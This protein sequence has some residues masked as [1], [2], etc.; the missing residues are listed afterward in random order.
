MSFNHPTTVLVIGGG[1]AGIMAAITAAREG[2][3][4]TILEKNERIG[5]K[6]LATGNGRCNLTNTDLHLKH[7]HGQNPKFAYTALTEFNY[8]NTIDFFA[9]LG[10]MPKTETGGKVFPFSGQASSVLDVLRFEMEQRKIIVICQADINKIKKTDNNFYATCKDGRKF[11][12]NRL[13]LAAGGKAS[14]NLGSNG[15]GFS[16]AQSLGHHIIEP[17]PALV[18]LQLAESFLKQVQGFK[19][20][21]TAEIIV[22][23]KA[24]ARATGEI[25]FTANGISG[26]PILQLSRKA[27]EYL[28]KQ[29]KVWLKLS[30][31]NHLS[32]EQLEQI[33]L[34]RWHNQPSQSLAFSFTGFIHKRIIPAML[35]AAGIEDI[36]KKVS[37]LSS[38]E[39]KQIA[40]ILQD[41]RFQV[42]GTDSWSAA[43]VTAGGVAVNEVN[44]QTLESKKVKGLYLAGEILDID[45]DCGGYNLQWAWSSGYIAGK[46]AAFV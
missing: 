24:K 7:Y 42:T 46:N 11:Q 5:R 25:L 2:A 1:A 30:L 38:K 3:A 33:L 10:I 9:N 21:G 4:A 15:S 40:S 6:I 39:I 32:T 31:I 43:Q 29:L 16:L 28:Q 18:R 26:P 27:G 20:E 35:K 17:F 23:N 36:N 13:I 22:D 44:P 8:Q 34:K 14:P 12:A 45:G 37:N 19:F 41:W